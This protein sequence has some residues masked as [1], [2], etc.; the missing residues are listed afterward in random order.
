VGEA[1]AEL[2]D[3]LRDLGAKIYTGGSDGSYLLS[4]LS[5]AAAEFNA[6][7]NPKA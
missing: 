7:L 6:K 5:K 4:A 1:G 2:L 3:Q